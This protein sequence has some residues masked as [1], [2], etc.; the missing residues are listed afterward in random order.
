MD[1]QGG[2]H[3]DDE[4]GFWTVLN[5]AGH[6]LDVEVLAEEYDVWLESVSTGSFLGEGWWSY[7]FMTP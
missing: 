4:V 7:T 1:F 6:V 2:A 5:E 3:D